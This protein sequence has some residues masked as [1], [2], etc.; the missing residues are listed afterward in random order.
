M[1]S[2]T[3]LGVVGCG[4]MGSGI[5]EVAALGGL[6]VRVAEA[7]PDAVEPGRRRVTASLDRGVQR[8]KITEEQRDQALARL[9]FTH[10]LSDLSDRQFVVEAVAENREIKTDVLRSLDKAVEDPAA[11]LAT[12]TSSIPV[13][14]LAV[15]TERPGQVIGMHFFNPVPVQRLVELVPALTTSPDT[16]QRTRDLA[17]QLGKQPIQAPD[18]SGFVVNALLVP[19]LLSA[20]RMVES[21]GARPQDIDQGM[22][23]GCAHPM[24]PLRLLDLIGLDTAQAVAESMYEE[25]KEPLYAPPALLRR[26][27]AAG[28]LGRKNGRGFYA[29]DA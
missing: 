28:H 23:L 20:V 19:Y 11:I 12:N 26:M 22:E 25:F 17:T 4:L 14:D 21:G 2:V 7:T 13:V 6:D 29:Y 9:S 24:G 3:R 1:D 16:V 5:A 27:V 18:R 15:A 8:G 10:D